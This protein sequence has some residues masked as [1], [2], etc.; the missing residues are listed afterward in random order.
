MRRDRDVRDALDKLRP[1]TIALNPDAVAAVDRAPGDVLLAERRAA[2]EEEA[3]AS[4]GI[5]AKKGKS[6]GRSH[7][8]RLRAKRQ[9]NVITKAKQLMEE[10]N[11]KSMRAKHAKGQG[12]AASS[13]EQASKAGAASRALKRFF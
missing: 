9:A 6:R 2:A 8:T 5:R 7:S 10:R 4:G 1:D 11:R 13:K 12:G 3:E